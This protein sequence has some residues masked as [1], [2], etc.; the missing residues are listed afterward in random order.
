MAWFKPSY[1]AKLTSKDIRDTVKDIPDDCIDGFM[2]KVRQ[3]ENMIN[4]GKITPQAR[5][6]VEQIV[7]AS[8]MRSGPALR[9]VCEMRGRGHSVVF[10]ENYQRSAITTYSLACREA[11]EPLHGRGIYV[12]EAAKLRR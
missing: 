7:V 2:E 12:R 10:P 8:N 6:I 1:N 9:K 11:L 4:W 3:Q 5:R